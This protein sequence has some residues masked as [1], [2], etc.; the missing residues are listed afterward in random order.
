M[1]V[2]N[3]LVGRNVIEHLSSFA[4]RTRGALVAAIVGLALAGCAETVT[5]LDQSAGPQGQTITARAVAFEPLTGL[6]DRLAPQFA[7]DLGTQAAA[8]GLTVVPREETANAYKVKGYFSAV[9][10][11]GQSRVF[12]VWDI[13]D[14]SGERTNRIEGERLVD[15]SSTDPWANVTPEIMTE[16][17]QSSISTLTSYVN[18]GAAAQADA[19]PPG[20]VTPSAGE[21][22]AL[23]LTRTDDS[24]SPGAQRVTRSD[25]AASL[26]SRANAARPGTGVHVA[27]VEGMEGESGTILAEALRR[28]LAGYGLRVVIDPADAAFSISGEGTHSVPQGARHSVGIIWTITRSAGDR[29]GT[30]RQINKLAPSELSDEWPVAARSAASA[31]AP[32]IVLLINES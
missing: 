21:T 11:G 23:A 3:L 1:S 15:G 31:A 18:Q 30:V 20:P 10:N 4:E 8:A 26:P 7:A 32:G 29:L 27:T 5:G 19:L 17:A 9:P 14:A 25:N 13:F 28:E 16:I 2:E 22:E 12:Y 24:L 6:P